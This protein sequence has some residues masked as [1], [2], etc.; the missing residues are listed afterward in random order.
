V[1]DFIFYMKQA[2]ADMITD[3]LM[4]ILCVHVDRNLEDFVTWVDTS[5]IRRHI[6]EYSEMVCTLFAYL[7]LF[8]MFVLQSNKVLLTGKNVTATNN[9]D[10]NV[11]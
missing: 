8:T 5:A 9:A 4:C 7:T 2:C 11:A 6:M 1:L 3:I 10:H